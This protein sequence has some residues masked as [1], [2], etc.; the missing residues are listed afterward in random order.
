M[1][2][3]TQQ[4]KYVLS[5]L[6]CACLFLSLSTAETIPARIPLQQ[7]AGPDALTD[8]EYKKSVLDWNLQTTVEFYRQHGQRN[9]AWDDD[10][11]A[12]LTAWAHHFTGL[13]FETTPDRLKQLAQRLGQA[14]CTDPLVAYCRAKTYQWFP[15]L[16]GEAAAC[17]QLVE[18]A[19]DSPALPASR[20]AWA[21]IQQIGRELNRVD[22]TL[23]R[24][25]EL[26]ARYSQHLK[27]CIAA[28][29][30][31]G[32]ERLFTEQVTRYEFG[33]I[34]DKKMAIH[35]AVVEAMQPHSDTWYAAT[36]LGWIEIRRAWHARD[37]GK[38]PKKSKRGL[39]NHMK[40][41]SSWLCRAYQQA[42]EPPLAATLMITVSQMHNSDLNPRQWF[43]RA[44]AAQ[45]DYASAYQRYRWSLAPRWGGD[46]AV[47]MAFA[48]ECA[49]TGRF[50]TSVP[51]VFLDVIQEIVQDT[52]RSQQS[53]LTDTIFTNKA[54]WT[55][56]ETLLD[57]LIAEPNRDT[58]WF[59]SQKA[60]LAWRFGKREIARRV[61]AD[62]AD[63]IHSHAF[64]L[65]D[66]K[67]TDIEGF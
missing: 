24:T 44:V 19:L 34:S 17:H 40:K 4:K 22:M 47:M 37:N 52:K 39:V 25:R 26:A 64:T 65:Y 61:L 1:Q 54:Y 5:T 38:S 18:E 36:V 11:E 7:A 27:E 30:Y 28:Q 12:L 31:E 66:V 42:P 16:Q 46:V 9:T 55:T 20:K 21:T 51:E 48:K 15:H 58:R 67:R 32:I 33:H 41:A 50:D 6:T 43:D 59:L 13:P 10:A 62:H 56:T 53:K 14:G 8:A 2:A 29:E 57:R 60:A 23:E 49:D 45:F 63:Q 3:P 35:S